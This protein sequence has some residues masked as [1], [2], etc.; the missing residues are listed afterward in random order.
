MKLPCHFC[1]E[2]VDDRLKGT[3][4]RVTGWAENRDQGGTNALRIRQPTGQVAHKA[5]VDAAGRGF[6]A[7]RMF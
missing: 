5:C 3:M 2:I 7:E 6:T 1:G 4:L